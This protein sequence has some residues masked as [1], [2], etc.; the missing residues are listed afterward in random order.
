MTK[1]LCASSLFFLLAGGLWGSDLIRSGDIYA[2]GGNF[3]G[4]SFTYGV[5]VMEAPRLSLD[6]GFLVRRSRVGLELGDE[7]MSKALLHRAQNLAITDRDIGQ[8]NWLLGLD[9][10]FVKD[11]EAARGFFSQAIISDPNPPIGLLYYLGW[12]LY[13]TGEYEAARN[14][15]LNLYDLNNDEFPQG[16][17]NLLL[18]EIAFH[19]AEIDEAKARLVDVSSY[20]NDSWYREEGLYL[21]GYAAFATDSLQESRGYFEQIGDSTRR[22]L[23]LARV[24]LEETKFDEAAELYSGLSDEEARYGLATALYLS[25]KINDAESKARDYLSSYPEGEFTQA[26]YLL[27]AIIERGKGRN[28]KA[29]EE[30]DKGLVFYSKVSPRLMNELA[31]IE[32]SRKRY[33]RSAEISSALLRDYPLYS[34]SDLVRLLEARSFFYQGETDSCIKMLEQILTSADDE[35]IA[36]ETHYYM[37]EALARK[38]E[39]SRAAEEFLLVKEGSSHFK[40]LKR[41]GE[42]LALAGRNSEAVLSFREALKEASTQY[43]REDLFLAIE[44]RRL[45]MGYYK[46]KGSMMKSYLEL[47]PDAVQAPQIALEIALD[48]VERRNW[49]T[50]LH[51]LNK[52]LDRYPDSEAAAEALYYKA[53][54]Q[55]S[56][57]KTDEALETYKQIADRYPSSPVVSRSQTEIASLLISLGRANEALSVY[58]NLYS[59]TRSPSE[60]ASYTLKMAEIYYSQGNA[61]TAADLASAALAES[62]S[63]EIT[64]RILLFG[65]DVELARG[66][67]NSAKNYSVRYR[68]RFGDTPEYLLRKASIDKASGNLKDALSAYREASSRLPER[69]ESRID[70]LIGAAETAYLLGR[71][72]EAR[73]YL[74]Q[75]A[76]EVQLDRQRVEITRKLQII[77]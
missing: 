40:A 37:G 12:S 19:E 77:K 34:A 52:L 21:A 45:A 31:E 66:N 59:S 51:E 6:L 14:A 5:A 55:R 2:L 68:N 36:N 3:D 48:Y 75:A 38:G 63:A 17:L 27:L 69:S 50:A 33:A 20:P 1:S 56:L 26:A 67:L 10:F 73:R 62:P 29:V 76:I 41:R 24:A 44:E 49:V 72:E 70:A 47:Y 64:Q 18:A 74:E 9:A 58:R 22:I 8:T 13:K 30:L 32:F 61:Q 54:C 60:R 28:D 42:V 15:L 4:A 39:Y 57:G 25:G 46:D 11:Y 71:S 65:M 53:R 16:E 43:D 7:E 35:V 23:S